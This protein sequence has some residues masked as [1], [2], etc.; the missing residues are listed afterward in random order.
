MG[1]TDWKAGGGIVYRFHANPNCNQCTQFPVLHN[2]SPDQSRPHPNCDCEITPELIAGVYQSD[3]LK[4]K[5]V[6]DTSTYEIE[7]SQYR[8]WENNTNTPQTHAFTLTDSFEVNAS[9]SQ[10]TQDEFTAAAGMKGSL[11]VTDSITKVVQP[12][13]TVRVSA[14]AIVVVKE[15][16]ADVY[17]LFSDGT[18]V[19]DGPYDDEGETLEGY[20]IVT[21][22]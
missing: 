19:Y 1:I 10:K 8:E 17:F 7:G 9:I 16:T 13:E 11:S 21:D 15:F 3:V 12:G 2:N 20:R 5:S 14:I 6:S 4:N 18:E 22:D